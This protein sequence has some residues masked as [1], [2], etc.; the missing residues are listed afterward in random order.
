M[1]DFTRR[2]SEQSKTS[3]HASINSVIVSQSTMSQITDEIM[4]LA[5]NEASDCLYKQIVTQAVRNL[6]FE[7]AIE[8]VEQQ[9]ILEEDAIALATS[10]LDKLIRTEINIVVRSMQRPRMATRNSTCVTRETMPTVCDETANLC[11]PPEMRVKPSKCGPSL[12]H[13]LAPYPSRPLKH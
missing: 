4:Q 7:A 3:K 6:L 10:L 11:K 5:T 13:K 9:F 1:S 2:V 8:A 12:Q